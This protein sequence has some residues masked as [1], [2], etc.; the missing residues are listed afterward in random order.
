MKRNIKR[1]ISIFLA[2]VM[3]FGLMSIPAGAA[4]T[5]PVQQALDAVKADFPNG[6]FFTTDGKKGS[7]SE[8]TK[9]ATARGV[10][11]KGYTQAWTCVAY[12]KYV[13]AKVFGI[14]AT[15]AKNRIEVGSGRAGVITTWDN[16][17]PGDL[18]YFYSDANLSNWHHAAIFLGK[19]GNTISLVDCNYANRDAKK[20]HNKILY[21]SV[22]C[23]SGGWPYSYV[24]VYH[25]KNYESICP[26]ITHTVT[27]DANG[28]SVSPS[29]QTVAEGSLIGQLP[30][31]TRTGYQFLGWFDSKNSGSMEVT[32]GS[33]YVNEDQ[34]LYALWK[35][36]CT[37]HTYNEA[38][39]CTKCGAAL[40]YDN[41]FD[42]SAAG[43]YQVSAR[44]V[45]VRT[46]PYEVKAAARTLRQGETAEIVGSVVNSYH[47]TWLKTSDGYYIYGERLERY[48]A[49]KPPV[50]EEAKSFQ[51]ILDDGYV[52]Q[53]MTVT[54]GQPYGTLPTPSKDGYVFDGW[55]TKQSGGEKITASTV[56]NLTRDQTLYAHW[57]KW[58]PWS[59]WSTTPVYA[60]STR[61]VETRQVKISDSYTEYRYGRYVASGHDCWCGKYLEGLSYVSE[62]ARLQYSPWSKTQYGTSGKGWSCGRCSA[63]HIGVDHTGSDGRSW[64]A[65]YLL[66]D[67]S[68]YW[69]E[70]QTVGAVYETQYRYRDLI[71]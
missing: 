37:E 10:S 61:Q 24:R 21:Y 29:A 43:T 40:D 54:N 15:K 62:S 44:E 49:P 60:S 64:W 32:P 58:G 55:Y 12:A 23:G 1:I 30:T 56:V 28:G 13:W 6:S 9:V 34:T 42:S 45:Y 53:M 59:E 36:I 50:P 66:P 70:T 48:S 16:A 18:I 14:E 52:C 46:G 39:I 57:K 38:G 3:I 26:P 33:I 63:S 67:G 7:P 11:C 51:V 41:G 17:S 22:T 31:P 8:F 20:E 2:V 5:D 25:A 65:E 19:S 69:Q 35:P 4:S 71:Q 47:N 68:Y 27:F